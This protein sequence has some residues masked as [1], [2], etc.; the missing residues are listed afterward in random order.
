MKFW[1]IIASI[2]VSVLAW[3][4]LTRTPILRAQDEGE[5]VANLQGSWVANATPN[6]LFLCGGP[7]IAPAGPPFT[8]LISYAAG[9]TLT[10]TNT[11][12]YFNSAGVV[13]GLPFD[14]S[15]GHGAWERE[16]T[17]YQATFRKLLFDGKG[18]YVANAD[19]KEKITVSSSDRNKLSADF[20]VKFNFLNGAPSVCSSG[21]LVAKRMAAD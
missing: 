10:E 2:M 12:V 19:I 3:A 18:V 13:P 1:K 16:A 9:G 6:P 8:E 15:D 14:G 20:T 5:T 4:F 11:I 17:G 21:T 7:E